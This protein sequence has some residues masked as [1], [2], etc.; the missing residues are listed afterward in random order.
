MTTVGGSVGPLSFTVT[1]L[2]TAAT[3]SVADGVNVLQAIHPEDLATVVAPPYDVISPDEHRRLLAR[4][5]GRR[6]A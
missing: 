5:N 3:S 4:R 1:D 2:E 6:S